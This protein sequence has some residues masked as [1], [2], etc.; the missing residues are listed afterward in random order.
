MSALEMDSMTYKHELDWALSSEPT[1]EAAMQKI[2]FLEFPAWGLYISLQTE[3][4]AAQGVQRH[5]T[6]KFYRSTCDLNDE[7][8]VANPTLE[9]HARLKA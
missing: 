6:W 9:A 1:K 7:K 5:H 2:P 3:R 8:P 4:T